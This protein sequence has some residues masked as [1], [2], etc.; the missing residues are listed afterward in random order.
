ML[1]CEVVGVLQNMVKIFVIKLFSY[2]IYKFVASTVSIIILIILNKCYFEFVSLFKN[3]LKG[4]KML[5]FNNRFNNYHNYVIV[6]IISAIMLTNCDIKQCTIEQSTSKQ[7][8]AS[9]TPKKKID[10]EKAMKFPIPQVL[11]R[12]QKD[13]EVSEKVAREHEKEL[14]RFLI[15]CAE[16][17]PNSTD[18]FS[19]EIDNLWHTFLLFTKDYAQYCNENFGHFVH[20]VPKIIE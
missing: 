17:H 4:I 16:N 3:N 9:Y 1:H 2:K 8:L 5:I 11:K 12:Y 7:S 20:H 10:I 13:Y 6:M 19:Q 15:I 18:M 14:K